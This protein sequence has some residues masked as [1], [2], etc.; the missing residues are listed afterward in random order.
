MILALQEELDNVRE[1]A[2]RSR[3]RER[4]SWADIRGAPVLARAV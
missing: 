3:E 4:T 2:Q 1:E